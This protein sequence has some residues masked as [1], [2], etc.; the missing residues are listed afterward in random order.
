MTSF[1][2][3]VETLTD[4]TVNQALEEI[5]EEKQ[6]KLQ[7]GDITQRIRT[8]DV[9]YIKDLIVNARIDVNRQDND[10]EKTMLMYAAE[11]GS[12]TI[13][14]LLC[15]YGADIDAQCRL[16]VDALSY[17]RRNGNYHI[18]SLLIFYRLGGSVGT[19]IKSILE[20]MQQQNGFIQYSLKKMSKS[21]LDDIVAFMIQNI[22]DQTPF[23]DDLLNLSWAHVNDIESE[24]F[25]TLMTTYQSI[26]TDTKNKCG[27]SYLKNYFMK[28]TLWL[29]PYPA[30]K[31][32]TNDDNAKD[33]NGHILSKHIGQYEDTFC[34]CN[35]C[36]YSLEE[37]E[38]YYHCRECDFFCCHICYPQRL[39]KT[40][41]TDIDYSRTLYNE[42][43]ERIIQETKVCAQNDLS[44]LQDIATHNASLWQQMVSFNL[45]TPGTPRQDRIAGGME[46]RYTKRMLIKDKSSI[47]F[48]L[49]A[50]Y[51][52]N[53]YLNRMV[54]KAN[55]MD[56]EFQNDM[57]RMVRTINQDQ[58]MVDLGGVLRYR[59][60]P[61][62]EQ[63]RAKTK[64]EV[65]YAKEEYP[66]ASML[67]DLNR[68][69]ISCPSIES[70]MLGLK[71]LEP[72]IKARTTCIVG[73][74]RC[75]NGWSEYSFD[76][77]GYCDIKLNV[78]IQTHRNGSLIGEVQFLLD[79]M[80]NYKLKAHRLYSIE[81]Y[82][83]FVDNLKSIMPIALN[84]EQQLFTLAN[85]GDDKGLVH[86]MVTNDWTKDTSK[87]LNRNFKNQ[88]IL[89][90]MCRFD[91]VKA[92]TTMQK[93]CDA[94]LLEERLHRY[95]D[96]G[97]SPIG[98][99]L[100]SN[101]VQILEL[102]IEAYPKSL[103]D[104]FKEERYRDMHDD[105]DDQ[106]ILYY[107]CQNKNIKLTKWA[108]ENIEHKDEKLTCLME[109]CKYRHLH[110]VQVL[111]SKQIL[112]GEDE[113]CAE[114]AK[115]DSNGWTALHYAAKCKG[116]KL[117]QFILDVI[118][119]DRSFEYL[120]E[121][122]ADGD[123]PF[124]I[125][126]STSAFKLDFF[127]HVT[128][129]L[130]A[131]QLHD[132]AMNENTKGESCIQ[133]TA[134]ASIFEHLFD[135]IVETIKDKDVWIK[136]L[137]KCFMLGCNMTAVSAQKAQ[138]VIR[139]YNKYGIDVSGVI[140]KETDMNGKTILMYACDRGGS[141]QINTVNLLLDHLKTDDAQLLEYIDVRD[142]SGMSALFY[143]FKS[144]SIDIGK[145]LF[146]LKQKLN[147]NDEDLVNDVLLTTDNNGWN[148][149]HFAC[150]NQVK[151]MKFICEELKVNKDKLETVITACNKPNNMT[152]LM[153]CCQRGTGKV[154][155]A[156]YLLDQFDD[157]K[158][159]LQYIDIKNANGK[160]AI[161]IANEKKNKKLL[162]LLQDSRQ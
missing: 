49:I 80:A 97:H 7:W 35:D 52:V 118:P 90:S 162:K 46:A 47:G 2:S 157:V 119:N 13:A 29:R 101:S 44:F 161:D 111:L 155:N 9:E 8:N 81:R 37:N 99:A 130:S 25:K 136:L 150:W 63:R 147:K 96:T 78:I 5:D 65:D 58:Q 53:I 70:M 55:Q 149:F 135:A 73:I 54:L 64:V 104:Y 21:Q 61:V 17:A 125:L 48:N 117:V 59:R 131:S 85:F 39:T 38:T 95:D 16:M 92:F 43:Y 146:D 126:C 27:W 154:P 142:A 120:N 140:L 94:K 151:H 77:P 121:K 10:H 114:L 50:H 156:K 79:L 31:G 34:I 129:G 141:K 124:Q 133:K 33:P 3:K 116:Y 4:E 45:N 12:Y 105:P 93:L 26:I 100:A 84:L 109:Y 103:L 139:M 159:K 138:S 108:L 122:N 30:P 24:L 40:A 110:V 115:K 143:A 107:S 148:L 89:T 74:A 123:T 82:Q 153:V 128:N 145:R 86:Y 88:S 71:I 152:P 62:K 18:A 66:S 15:H 76:K 20:T 83:E 144:G 112:G 68:C 75:K 132:L 28:S 67:L 60:G 11:Y 134:T 36:G 113:K 72:M 23:S 102:L 160:S 137:N 1:L 69:T 106:G 158:S 98:Y 91:C 56:Q 22:R 57:Q 32:T 19:Q 51:D 87:L 42:L 14:E 127:K 6:P 41:E